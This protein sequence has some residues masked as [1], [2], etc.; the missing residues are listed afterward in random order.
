MI[1][2]M[3][4]NIIIIIGPCIISLNKYKYLRNK[5]LVRCRP[6]NDGLNSTVVHE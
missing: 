4:D 3:R 2:L 6:V 1:L 5:Y